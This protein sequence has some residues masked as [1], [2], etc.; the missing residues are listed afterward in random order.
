MD[1]LTQAT[2]INTLNQ[3][4]ISASLNGHNDEIK[5][6]LGKGA[7]IEAA[8]H[9][10]V[11]AF[12]QAAMQGH[13]EIVNTFLDKGVDINHHSTYGT[14]ALMYAITHKRTDIVN[15]LLDNNTDI[16]ANNSMMFICAVEHG[17]A[18]TV[19]IFL[20]KG[21]DINAI[22]QAQ[23][24]R[25]LKGSFATDY[26]DNISKALELSKAGIKIPEDLT[27]YPKEMQEILAQ[28]KN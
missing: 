2:N 5:K 20:E 16:H 1:N 11:T 21:A 24:K 12:M 7:N 8:D 14:T 27:P 18:E 26:K 28:F 22:S 25:L 10:G 19:K 9:E 3:E 4:L 6:L 17:N 23:F 15:R 13:T